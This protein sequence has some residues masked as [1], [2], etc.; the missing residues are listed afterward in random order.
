MKININDKIKIEGTVIAD[1]G[2]YFHMRI[3][4]NVVAY[5]LKK[6]WVTGIIE[7]AE[8][9]QETIDRLQ[10]RNA[11]LER[12]LDVFLCD[13]PVPSHVD[14]SKQTYDVRVGDLDK[15]PK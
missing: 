2:E 12:L 9:P 1:C 8:S 14:L 5:D 13:G 6:T 7:R 10:A 4:P 15:N 11:E 3:A